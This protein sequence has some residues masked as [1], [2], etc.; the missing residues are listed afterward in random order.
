MVTSRLLLVGAVLVTKAAFG[1]GSTIDV[2]G[3]P[4]NLAT[5][6]SVEVTRP[7]IQAAG[8][9]HY[10]GVTL[11][12]VVALVKAPATA[13]TVLLHFANG[14]QVPLP[15]DPKQWRE[16][17]PFIALSV[18]RDGVW[19]AAFPEVT[20]A[21][22]EDRD[23]R[24]LVF[25][26]NKFVVSTTAHAAVPEV[27]RLNGFTPFAYV[28]SLVAVE[29]VS[30][31]QRERALKGTSSETARDGFKVF[32]GR[33]QFCHGVK[34]AG[35]KYGPDFALPRLAEKDAREL[36]LHVR[37]RDRD[38]AEKGLMMPFFKDVSAEDI[39][40]LLTWLRALER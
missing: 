20:K 7:D 23:A 9:A 27:A 34:L 31:A 10:R 11:S 17:D 18:E 6:K 2:A 25:N 26:G 4:V 24:P 35:A 32:V 5:L 22:A 30:A 33:C 16:L 38:A 14:M 12:S 21:G 19:S 29:L 15:R 40:A 13:D 28:D 37:Y 36:L 39:K 8:Q 1:A 3:K